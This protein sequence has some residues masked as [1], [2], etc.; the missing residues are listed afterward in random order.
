[1]QCLF[2]CTLYILYFINNLFCY[3]LNTTTIYEIKDDSSQICGLKEGGGERKREQ[4]RER[5]GGE[6]KE[7]ERKRKREKERKGSTLS[8]M[9]YIQSQSDS[10]W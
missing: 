2:V 5:G 8:V 4:K 9:S 6:K 10:L 7:K 3:S 1:M